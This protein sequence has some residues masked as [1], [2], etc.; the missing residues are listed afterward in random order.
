MDCA[1]GNPGLDKSSM[2]PDQAFVDEKDVQQS[3]CNGIGVGLEDRGSNLFLYGRLV[4][5]EGRGQKKE[6]RVWC[7]FGPGKRQRRT[8]D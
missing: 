2:D 7:C 5:V 4:G 6:K 3:D 8:D 1:K